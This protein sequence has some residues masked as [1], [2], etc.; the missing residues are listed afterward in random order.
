M[1]PDFKTYLRESI[2]SEMQD[3]G[4]GDSI[5]TEDKVDVDSL[6]Y[7]E[8]YDY[9]NNRY[10][11]TDSAYYIEKE[12]IESDSYGDF[13]SITIPL[14]N[15][16][17][18][19]GQENY[20]FLTLYYTF[21]KNVYFEDVEDWYTVDKNVN[22]SIVKL[23][24]FEE[25]YPNFIDDLERKY[26]LE[27]VSDSENNPNLFEVVVSPKHETDKMVTHFLNVLDYIIDNVNGNKITKLISK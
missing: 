27:D 10:K 15:Y 13:L 25:I 2:W 23:S 22:I 8:L 6:S 16:I 26:D 18:K 5:K 19:D 20:S 1:I 14:F 17:G 24:E 11:L 9:L 21:D 4:T 3:R 7:D 12:H